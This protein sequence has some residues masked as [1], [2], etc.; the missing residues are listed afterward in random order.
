MSNQRMHL[1]SSTCSL[2]SRKPS[3]FPVYH[4]TQ[5]VNLHLPSPSTCV[6]MR[7]QSG[8]SKCSLLGHKP[9]IC[10]HS[11][12]SIMAFCAS[13]YGPPSPG[14]ARVDTLSFLRAYLAI[15]SSIR[16]KTH[17]GKTRLRVTLGIF[18]LISNTQQRSRTFLN[19]HREVTA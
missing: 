3:T 4:H 7:N 19:S 9:T 15:L 5:L 1:V 10:P 17:V 2:L 14:T 12:R 16:S 6:Q 8:S 13:Y 11:P 18:F